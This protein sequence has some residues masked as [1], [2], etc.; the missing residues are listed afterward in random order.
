MRTYSLNH[1]IK[2]LTVLSTNFREYINSDESDKNQM[3]V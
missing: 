3:S 1:V 2:F